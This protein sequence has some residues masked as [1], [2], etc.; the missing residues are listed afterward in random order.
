VTRATAPALGMRQAGIV[1]TLRTAGGALVVAVL[2]DRAPGSYRQI[3]RALT[4][5]A[6]AGVVA[7]EQ[8]R[9]RMQAADLVRLLRPGLDA[10]D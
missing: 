10:A 1:E 7:V 4:G 8:R 2:A 9:E 6:A 5:L 3:T